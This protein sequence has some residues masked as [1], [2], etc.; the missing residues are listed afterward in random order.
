MEETDRRVRRTRTLLGKALISVALRKGYEHITIQDIT[1][2]A[3]VGYRTYFRHYSGID[4][5]LRD[6]AQA[7]LDE[8]D[9]LLQLPVQRSGKENPQAYAEESGRILFEYIKKNQDMFRILL[10]ERGVWF[11][12]KPVM[13]KARARM[14]EFLEDLAGPEIPVQIVPNHLIGSTFALMRWWL[15]NNMPYPPSR[16]GEIFARLIMYPT[17]NAVMQ[18][19]TG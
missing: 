12:L 6:V 15:E 9:S 19:Q 4:D 7:T 14:E 2:E 11:C 10:L 13:E 5:L 3:D 18:E 1:E 8:L 16:M 17:L